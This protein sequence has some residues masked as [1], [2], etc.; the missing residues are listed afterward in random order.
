MTGII[1]G[2]HLKTRIPFTVWV[3]A[4]LVT[5]SSL[6]PSLTQVSPETHWRVAEVVQA[7]QHAS[8]LR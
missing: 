5:F 3:F 4:A 1:N 2:V 6:V 8:L 7:F